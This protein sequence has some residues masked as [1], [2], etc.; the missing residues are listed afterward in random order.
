MREQIQLKGFIVLAA[1]LAWVGSVV[2]HNRFLPS[3]A[4]APGIDVVFVPSGIRLF[5]IL[6]GGVWAAI[7]VSAGSLLLTG[8][9]FGM[10]N[11]GAII[12]IAICSGFCP[13]IALRVTLRALGVATD[14]GNL[15]P[16]SL[17][18][19]SLGVAV[20]SS[21]LHNLVFSALGLEPWHSLASN[22]MA[23]T[24]GDFI[25]RFVAVAI[26]FLVLRFYSKRLP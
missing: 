24:T 23:M 9:E 19:V 5:A 11:A 6:I 21:L 13:Y 12:L 7:G 26:V 10:S 3:M 18:L 16:A 25:G 4:Y 8:Q 1:A 2:L 15:R 14:L 20:G 17:P 22:V